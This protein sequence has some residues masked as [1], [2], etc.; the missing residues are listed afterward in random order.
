MGDIS[1]IARRLA[2]GHV[3]HGWSGNGGYFGMVGLRLLQ[4]YTEPEKVE[5]LFSLGQLRFLGAPGSEKGGFKF[6]ETHNLTGSPHYLGSSE[7]EIFSKIAFVDYGYLYDIDNK[8]YYIKPGHMCIKIP[9]EHIL[10]NID[11]RGFE[12]NYMRKLDYKIFEYILKVYVKENIDFQ[13][14]MNEKGYDSE[15]LF[16]EFRDE[17]WALYEFLRKYSYIEEYF[18]SWIVVETNDDYT[19]VIG[20]KLKPKTKDHIE[21]CEW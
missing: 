10:F 12:F 20:F 6:M 16:E 21:T 18:D 7:E 1:I 14:F 19:E 3:Q 11:E 2:D 9:L 5:Y 17:E 4:W 15:K 13:S 8:W